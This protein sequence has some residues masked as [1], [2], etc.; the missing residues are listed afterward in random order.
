[1]LALQAH[2]GASV[3]ARFQDKHPCERRHA[4]LENTYR[5]YKIRGGA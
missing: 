3:V 1:M 5:G 2:A 4:I